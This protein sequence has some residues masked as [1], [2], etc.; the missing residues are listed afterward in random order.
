M[1][2]C[3]LESASSAVDGVNRASRTHS[4]RAGR[5]RWTVPGAIAL[6][7][8][9]GLYLAAQGHVG[10]TEATAGPAAGSQLVVGESQHDFG[11]VAAGAVLRHDFTIRNRGTT[12]IVVNRDTCCGSTDDYA[13]LAAGG[14]LQIPV[15]LDTSGQPR[16]VVRRI[17]TFTTSDPG[18][19]RLELTVTARISEHP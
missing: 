16:G 8:C 2:A 5:L 15:E 14:E 6:F 4:A 1:Q 13:I 12:R 3:K 10:D 18:R 19:P 9:A 7:V 11:S 17:E